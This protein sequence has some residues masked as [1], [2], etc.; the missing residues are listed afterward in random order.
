VAFDLYGKSPRYDDEQRIG[1][2]ALPHNLIA[3]TDEHGLQALFKQ[4]QRV[5]CQTLEYRD[6][7]E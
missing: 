3:S 4:A 5:R 6:A 1:V 7:C 2:F